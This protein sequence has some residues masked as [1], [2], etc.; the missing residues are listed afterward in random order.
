MSRSTHTS[1]RSHASRSAPNVQR[2]AAAVPAAPDTAGSA[3]AQLREQLS[4]CEQRL[5][6]AHWSADANASRAQTELQAAQAELRELQASVK[7]VVNENDSLR[8]DPHAFEAISRST[9]RLERSKERRYAAARP[10]AAVALTVCDQR[11]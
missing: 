4:E 6:E 2:S 7:E 10:R 11:A 1:P 8:H 3:E 5:E 9:W